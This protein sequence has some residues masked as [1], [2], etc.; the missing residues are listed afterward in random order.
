MNAWTALALLFPLVLGPQEAP[1][2]PA[3]DRSAR[4]DAIL[5][6]LDAATKAF[7]AAVAAAK[8][9]DARRALKGPDPAVYV[10]RVWEIVRE[11][12]RDATSLT[13]LT[14]LIEESRSE[15]DRDQ[16][17]AAIA[18]D[19]LES[20]NLASLCSSLGENQQIGTDLLEL[21]V[22]SNPDRNV[23]GKALYALATHR[24]ESARTAR[25][26]KSETP[27]AVESYKK[28]LGPSRTAE[29]QRLDPATSESEAVECLER[30]VRE[31][32]DV[33]HGQGTLAARAEADL[34]ELRELNI[35]KEAPEI[36]GED[37]DGVAFKLSDYRGKVV[38]LDFWGHW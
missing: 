6:E 35:G 18:K 34:R 14:W 36:A 28:F 3:N 16:A 11:D 1:A 27:E 12:P 19:H 37:L 17:I 25:R 24:L 23:K 15:T 8:T 30:V 22:T 13:A 4:L 29:L 10:P 2:K 20:P 31:F 7:R 5:G 9:D 26:L 32:G 21:L 38:L 33:E